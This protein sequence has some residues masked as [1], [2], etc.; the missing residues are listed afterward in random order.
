MTAKYLVTGASGKLGQSVLRHLTETYQV[1][2]GDIIAGS[3][4]PETLSEWVAKGIQTRVVDFDDAAS[5]EKAFAEAGRVLIIS[6]DALDRPGHRLIQHKA[7]IAAAE[8]AGV[9][10]LLYTSMPEPANSPL[11]FAPDH[12]G[13]EAAIKA[14]TIPAWTILRNNWYFENVFL[15]ASS[16]L[17]SGHWYS[18]A[19]GGG[20]AHI[21]RDDIGRAVAAALVAPTEGKTVYTLTGTKAYSHADIAALIGAAA[22]KKISVVEVPLEGLVQ[23]MVGAGLPEPLARVF[24]SVD[25]MI[26]VG[27]LAKVTADYKTLTGLEP[28]G[29]EA[30]VD[31]QA[32]AFNALVK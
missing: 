9:Q 12:E 20:I 32:A 10:H 3:R 30:W 13:T 18:A 4:K 17:A 2:P 15:S 28:Q 27:G 23:G 7:A 26:G 8:K 29:F 22:G 24:A 5:M 14:S 31:S 6:T 21:L 25:T 16:A 11:L 19:A 1:A